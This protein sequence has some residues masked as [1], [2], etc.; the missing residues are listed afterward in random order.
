MLID[1]IMEYDEALRKA[2]E[3]IPGPP[4][5]EITKKRHEDGSYAIDECLY[6]GYYILGPD[7][8][9]AYCCRSDEWVAWML[10]HQAER[11]V[12]ETTIVLANGL[13]FV[14][15]TIFLGVGHGPS[16]DG[17]LL[18]ET[19]VFAL[20]NLD[21]IEECGGSRTSVYQ[22]RCGGGRGEAEA[23]HK[24]TAWNVEKGL[25]P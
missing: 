2:L 4:S 24:V 8:D 1:S 23:M 20:D 5:I 15:S 10:D 12:D 14:V 3:K 18:W 7:E 21:D 16:D 19:M 13:G 11:R 25:I 6:Y 17:P 22:R 9:P